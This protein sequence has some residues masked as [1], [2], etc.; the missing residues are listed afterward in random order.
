MYMPHYKLACK[1]VIRQL[2][3]GRNIVWDTNDEHQGDS[4]ESMDREER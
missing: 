4:R 2:C 3:Q 1:C